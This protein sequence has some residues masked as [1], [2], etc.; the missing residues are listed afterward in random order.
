MGQ[1]GKN[2]NQEVIHFR[3]PRDRQVTKDALQEIADGLSAMEG[4]RIT[5]SEVIRRTLDLYLP[6]IRHNY[7]I[8]QVMETLLTMEF[9]SMGEKRYTV[10][11]LRDILRS[12]KLSDLTDTIDDISLLDLYHLAMHNGIRD[13][14]DKCTFNSLVTEL[15][16]QDTSQTDAGMPEKP[17]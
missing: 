9:R 7:T 1:R 2:N 12:I 5:V 3:I 14:L 4:E 10:I 16:A 15:S 11:R 13:T 17:V 8:R 6:V